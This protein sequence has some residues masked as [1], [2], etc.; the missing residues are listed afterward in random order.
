MHSIDKTVE[1]RAQ[2][3]FLIDENRIKQFIRSISPDNLNNFEIITSEG[4]AIIQVANGN[5]SNNK[6]MFSLIIP[7]NSFGWTYFS[8]YNSK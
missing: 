8:Q 6:R 5:E 2:A 7:S 4:E 3:I 1:P